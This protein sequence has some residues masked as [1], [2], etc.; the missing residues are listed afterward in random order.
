MTALELASIPAEKT[1]AL[2]SFAVTAKLICAF[3]FANAKCWF[4]HDAAQSYS[5]S[6]FF[7]VFT[8]RSMSK[9]L[10]QVVAKTM[11]NC[12]SCKV[13]GSAKVHSCMAQSLRA[14]YHAISDKVHSKS[15]RRR[16]PYVFSEYFEE[17]M[18][19]A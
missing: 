11:I 8:A 12:I 3:V 10:N 18:C 16:K 4:S 1:K 5:G 19:N 15:K 14:Q 17:Q 13:H 2:I 6:T 7:Y 9:T